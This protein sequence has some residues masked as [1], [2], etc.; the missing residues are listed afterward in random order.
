MAFCWW[1]PQGGS[2]GSWQQHLLQGRKS[3][4]LLSLGQS[5]A[6]SLVPSLLEGLTSYKAQNLYLYMATSTYK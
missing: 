1:S 5:E 2:W 3:M 4:V 6:A